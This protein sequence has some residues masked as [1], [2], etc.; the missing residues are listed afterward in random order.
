MELEAAPSVGKQAQAVSKV[1]PK[2]VGK[3]AQAVIKKPKAV[4]KKE[5]SAPSQIELTM[6]SVGVPPPPASSS[7]SEQA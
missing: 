4:A 6:A 1:A 3:K 5:A 2:S 7:D